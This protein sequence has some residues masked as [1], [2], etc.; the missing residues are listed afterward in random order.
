MVGASCSLEAFHSFLTGKMLNSAAV[1]QSQTN[2][3]PPEQPE[4]REL[5]V[6]RLDEKKKTGRPLKLTE[7]RFRR[8]LALIRE[9]NTAACRIEGI[10]YVTWRFH[11]Q[12][13]PHWRA[14]L[15]EA[16][17]IRDEV[18]RDHALEMVKN[19]MPKNWQAAMCYLE[20]RYPLEF[21][22]RI[23]VNRALNSTD[24]PIGDQVSEERLREYGRLMLEFAQQNEAK[25]P[26]QTPTLP[27]S[28][29]AAA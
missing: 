17:K 22:L 29:N 2:P 1:I 3:C 9:G 7:A 26:S 5:E 20:R 11:I 8:M 15:A 14:E 10:S 28:Q 18:W 21:S 12:Q 24:Q 6:V 23:P 4:I 25:A 16:E 13:K 19:A 27:S